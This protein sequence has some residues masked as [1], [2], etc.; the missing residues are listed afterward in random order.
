MKI[1]YFYEAHPVA[2]ALILLSFGLSVLILLSVYETRFRTMRTG[3]GEV[4]A[5]PFPAL[6]NLV[7]VAGHSVYTS[8]SCGKLDREDSWFLEPYQRHPG[9]AAT[10]LAHIKEGVEIAARDQDALLLFSGGETRKD[11]GPRSEAQSY[12]AIAESKGWYGEF[13]VTSTLLLVFFSRIII[14]TIGFDNVLL[15]SVFGSYKSCIS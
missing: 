12:W 5:Y 8:T 6:R 2:V 14:G 4:G 1:R 9:Q 13:Q 7:M 3:G 10:F 11:A 15:I